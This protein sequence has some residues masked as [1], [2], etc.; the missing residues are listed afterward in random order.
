V[1]GWLVGWLIRWLVD[2]L[3]DWS[4]EFV[5]ISSLVMLPTDGQ[6]AGP[7]NRRTCG[8]GLE[9]G[10]ECTGGHPFRLILALFLTS[11]GPLNSPLLRPGLQGPRVH[12]RG[13]RRGGAGCGAAFGPTSARLAPCGMWVQ[14]ELSAAGSARQGSACWGGYAAGGSCR[15]EVQ[16]LTMWLSTLRDLAEFSLFAPFSGRTSTTR[17]L[18]LWNLGLQRHRARCWWGVTCHSCVWARPTGWAELDWCG[19]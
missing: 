17:Q 7:H 2:C 6:V 18:S 1:C 15:G 14:T 13:L 10:G 16:V 8:L 9:V 4:E 3:I 11:T 19:T 12:L 5:W